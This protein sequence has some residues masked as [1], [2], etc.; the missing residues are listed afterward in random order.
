MATLKIVLKNNKKRAN[1]TY[2][3]ALRITHKGR[4]KY[5]FLKEFVKAEEWD[6]IAER[7]TKT[8]RNRSLL[9]NILAKRKLEV[10]NVILEFERRS[11][12]Y[13]VDDILNK[14]NSADKELYFD[15]LAEEMISK[16]GRQNSMNYRDTEF[17]R[18]NIIKRYNKNKKIKLGDLTESYL[19]KFVEH[20]KNVDVKSPNT[21]HKY[22]SL[23]QRVYRRALREEI[24]KG[25]DRHF[26]RV[27]AT[28]K[29]QPT[30]KVYLS[31]DEIQK[32]HDL[33]LNEDSTINDVRNI[34][35]FSFYLAGMR[36]E[37]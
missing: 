12:S 9:N 34:W 27:L 7:V 35:L 16:M 1:G 24:I 15:D 18:L 28:I 29:K 8:V 10:D 4:S 17:F 21:I 19:M 31:I 26:E 22:V 37:T 32:I 30:E 14:L 13:S 36:L 11:D 20:F 25:S 23:M 33:E 3:L 2:P 5:I 6:S